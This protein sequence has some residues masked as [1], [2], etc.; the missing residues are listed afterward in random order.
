MTNV[1]RQWQMYVQ[2][3][4]NMRDDRYVQ[5]YKYASDDKYACLQVQM[6]YTQ[7]QLTHTHTKW[8][9]C[10]DNNKCVQMV[11][12]ICEMTNMCKRLQICLLTSSDD[13]RGFRWPNTRQ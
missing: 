9:T 4:K 5:D 7:V 11:T 2:M 1:F 12:N 3:V 6:I 8:R 10:L 13:R